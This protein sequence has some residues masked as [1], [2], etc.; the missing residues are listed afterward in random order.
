M[1][2]TRTPKPLS[3]RTSVK[4]LTARDILLS[5]FCAC[6]DELAFVSACPP[7]SSVTFVSHSLRLYF[8]TKAIASLNCSVALLPARIIKIERIAVTLSSS[9]E[10]HILAFNDETAPAYSLLCNAARIASMPSL[11][12]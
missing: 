4:C 2:I 8:L 5:T 11:A 12:E 9:V 7:F 3:A 6:T 1:G 10:S